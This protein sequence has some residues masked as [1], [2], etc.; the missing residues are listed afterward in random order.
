MA[1]WA[2]V[3]TVAL[4]LEVLKPFTVFYL[5]YIQYIFNLW[6]HLKYLNN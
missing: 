3:F 2:L 6:M 5:T 1:V 4:W